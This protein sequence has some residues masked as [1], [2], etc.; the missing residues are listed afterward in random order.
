MK[1]KKKSIILLVAFVL[2]NCFIFAEALMPGNSS[3]AQSDSIA[4]V[5]GDIIKNG[6]KDNFDY[7]KPTKIE[8]I[9]TNSMFVGD[10]KKIETKI[11]PDNVTNN[12]KI[13]KSLNSDIASVDK[14]GFVTALKEGKATIR[15]I[16]DDDND[17]FVDFEIDITEKEKIQPESISFKNSTFSIKN[18]RAMNI[19]DIIG[20]IEYFPSECTDRSVRYELSNSKAMIDEN[21]LL[22]NEPGELKLKAVLNSNENIFCEM[23]VIILD[24]VATKPESISIDLSDVYIN[25]YTQIDV[26]F[27]RE[28]IDDKS[29][30]YFIESDVEKIANYNANNQLL[31]LKEGNATI[32]ACSIYDKSICSNTIDFEVRKVALESLEIKVDEFIS[33]YFKSGASMDLKYNLYPSDVTYKDIEWSV[34]N[35]NARISASG[36]LVGLK[37]GKTI[38]TLKHIDSGLVAT[39]EIKIGSASTLSHQEMNKLKG[40]VRKQIGHFGLFAIDGIIGFLFFMSLDLKK[41]NKIIFLISTGVIVAVVAELLQLIPKG[42]SCQFSDMLINFGGFITGAIASFVTLLIVKKVKNRKNK[43]G[44]QENE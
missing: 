3:G 4:N 11:T 17:V 18:K 26:E 20:E 31:G 34:S 16:C 30:I 13:Y 41:K 37:K 43:K 33:K 25:R 21:Y 44:D 40:T 6:G 12:A 2:F 5:F 9:S 42:R 27:D 7:I 35:D 1:L 14:N 22:T 38:V 39:K 15:V 32:K 24:D 29:L 28:N 23:D 8:V 36:L 10:T 19:Q